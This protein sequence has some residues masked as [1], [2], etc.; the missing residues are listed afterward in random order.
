MPFLSDCRRSG[1]PRDPSGNRITMSPWRRASATGASGSPVPCPPRLIG[2]I[3]MMC[4]A[5]QASQRRVMK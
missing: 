5:N 2:T 1:S 4:N 3:C